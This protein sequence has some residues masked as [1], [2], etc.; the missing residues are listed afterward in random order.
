MAAFSAALALLSSAVGAGFASGREILRFFASQGAMAGASI[1]CALGMMAFAFVRLPAQMEGCGCASLNTLYRARFG[2]GLGRLCAA[3]FYLLFA[4]TGGAMLA[5]CAELAA[6]TLNLH[7]AYAFGIIVSLLPA[8]YLAKR[9]VSGLAPAG[10]LLLILMPVLMLRLYALPAG[11]ACFLPAMAPDL[12]VRAVLDGTAYGALNAALLSGT[13]Q[14]LLALE[15]AVRRRAAAIFSA[16][17]GGL[18][19][20]GTAVCRRHLPAVLHQAMPFVYLSRALGRGGYILVAACLYAAA[21]STL[22][23]MLT[24]LRRMTGKRSR[25]YLPPLCCLLAAQMGFGP[26]IKSAYPTLGALCAGL[27]LLCLL[28][29]GNIARQ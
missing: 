27:M 15:P 26:I 21:F 19:L 2:D 17:F 22:L 11:E 1:A 13:L 3:L 9:G 14:M 18:L 28:P 5:A 12:P 6:L 25:P 8:A 20:L 10:A 24:G 16:L 7:H 4:I 29:G 23:A